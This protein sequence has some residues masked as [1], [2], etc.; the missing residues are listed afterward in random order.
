MASQESVLELMAQNKPYKSYKKVILGKLYVQYIDPLTQQI[1]GMIL[2][3]DPNKGE[4]TVIDMWSP[5]EDLFFR[6]SNRFH[7][8][9]GHLVE[10]KRKEQPLE[11][12]PNEV[13]DEEIEEVLDSRFFSLQNLLPKITSETTLLRILTIAREKQKSER[14]LTLI[15]TRLAEVQKESFGAVVNVNSNAD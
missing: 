5:L 3:G 13:T 8:E 10:Y 4:E 2:E 12:T 6:R 14:I 9:N 15:E 11:K 7:F 1:Q